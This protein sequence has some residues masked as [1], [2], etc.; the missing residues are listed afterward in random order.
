MKKFLLFAIVALALSSCYNTRI[1]VGNVDPKEPV[2]EV[3]KE[4]NHHLFYGLLPLNNATMKASEYVGGKT[5]Y[6]VKTN[7]S[8]LNM[9]VGSLTWGIYTP[10]QT[11]YYI[12]VKDIDKK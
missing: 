5:N 10:T 12:P 6:V 2:I 4:W 3:Q 8:F 9:L 11:I 1:L 7:Q